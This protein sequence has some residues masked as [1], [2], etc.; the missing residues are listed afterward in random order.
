M[1]ADANEVEWEA[2]SE[3]F[4]IGPKKLHSTKGNLMRKIRVDFTQRGI[5]RML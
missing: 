4:G 2:L 5:H 1:V 3:K